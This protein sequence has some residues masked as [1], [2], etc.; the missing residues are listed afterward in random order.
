MGA[1]GAG[2]KHHR[3]THISFSGEAASLK[4]ISYFG[5]AGAPPDSRVHP[6]MIES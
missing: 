1:I 4:G 5:A 6:S 3:L 2:V